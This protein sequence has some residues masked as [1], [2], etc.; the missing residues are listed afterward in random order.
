MN[1]LVNPS[2]SIKINIRR[3]IYICGVNFSLQ[4]DT[5]YQELLKTREQKF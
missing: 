4:H 1:D 5:V 3:A 2:S